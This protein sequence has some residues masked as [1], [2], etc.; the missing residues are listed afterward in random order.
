MQ[1]MVSWDRIGSDGWHGSGL[2]EAE[3]GQEKSESLAGLSDKQIEE[4]VTG[5]V[6]GGI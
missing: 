3:Y 4:R 2:T 5:L 6:K 1:D